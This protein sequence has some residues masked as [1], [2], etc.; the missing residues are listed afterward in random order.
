M[1]FSIYLNRRVLV[2]QPSDY[3]TNSSLLTLITLGSV[4][5]HVG[6][7]H[8]GAYKYLINK[9]KKNSNLKK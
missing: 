4:F 8:A 2:M 1:K 7:I 5:K 6:F 9:T 3:L